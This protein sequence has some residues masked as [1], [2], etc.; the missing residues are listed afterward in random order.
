MAIAQYQAPSYG[1]GGYVFP[2]FAV[3]LGNM[4]A[5]APL[6]VLISVGVWEISK[7]KG[8]IIEV[9][10]Y[11]PVININNGYVFSGTFIRW[12]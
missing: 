5:V 11:V 3:V 9:S 10:L 7:A 2:S 4:F 6:V 12:L 1:K 8:N